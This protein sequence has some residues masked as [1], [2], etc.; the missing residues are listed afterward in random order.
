VI[1]SQVRKLLEAAAKD[2]LTRLLLPSVQ[3]FI[4]I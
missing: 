4:Y 3:V 1:H 2:G